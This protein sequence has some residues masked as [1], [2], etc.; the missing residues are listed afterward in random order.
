MHHGFRLVS[1]LSSLSRFGVVVHGDFVEVAI[2]KDLLEVA[3]VVRFLLLVEEFL[4]AFLRDR[5][6]HFAQGFKVNAFKEWVALEC[7]VI[8]VTA[9]LP[10]AEPRKW[11][12]VQESIDQIDRLRFELIRK[13]QLAICN[14][15]ENFVLRRPVERDMA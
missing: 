5:G 2:A 1:L 6:C 15:L 13:V 3:L 4:V 14:F 9:P 8:I 12:H 11:I 10:R 7:R